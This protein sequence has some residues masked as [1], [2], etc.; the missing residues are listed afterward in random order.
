LQMTLSWDASLRNLSLRFQQLTGPVTA[1]G[2][3]DTAFYRYLRFVSLNEVGCNPG[4]FGLPPERFHQYNQ[5]KQQH[6]PH[7]QSATSTHDT[8]RGEDVRARLNVLS[9][10]P[11]EWREHIERWAGL[12]QQFK[13]Q[14]DGTLQPSANDE[15]LLYQILAGSWTGAD[16]LDEYI[17]RLQQYLLKARARSKGVH[18]LD[19]PE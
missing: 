12:N 9:E 19:R 4:R 5:D 11:G 10:M 2:L 13:T 17:A 3:E 7:S 16:D 8:K 6:W 14:S 15:Y 1:K 18:F